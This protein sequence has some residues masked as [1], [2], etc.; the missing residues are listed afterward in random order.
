V[1]AVS[2]YAAGQEASPYHQAQLSPPRQLPPPT[3]AAPACAT[4]APPAPP[5]PPVEGAA[6]AVA[7]G[8]PKSRC[9]QC[10]ESLRVTYGDPPLGA[11]VYAHGNT[12]VANGEAARMVL[13][14]YDFVDGQAQLNLRGYDQ[15]TKIAHL[16]AVNPAPLIIE[17]TVCAPAL[18]DARRLVVLN[19][20]GRLPCPLSPERVVVGKPIANG[21]S[22]TEAVFVYINLLSRLRDEGRA[23]VISLDIGFSGV[24]L[25]TAPSSQVNVNNI[26]GGSNLVGGSGGTE[27]P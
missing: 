10:I 7:P 17:R 3:P 6:V 21:L 18:A 8:W 25:P 13:Y 14:D 2:S 11:F 15:L 23:G 12:M 9:R 16:L 1:A 26:S 5:G 20:L 19:E 22:G 4:P 27:G 24:N